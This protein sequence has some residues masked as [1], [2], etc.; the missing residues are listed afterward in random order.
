MCKVI[1]LNTTLCDMILTLE[2]MEIVKRYRELSKMSAGALMPK[3]YQ[4]KIVQLIGERPL[5]D[6]GLDNV[7]AKCLWDTGS[8]ISLMSQ[9]FKDEKF[10]DK[11]MHTVHEFLGNTLSV[12][13]ANNTKV[14]IE[15]VILLDISIGGSAPFEVPFLVT[16]EKLDNPI[17]GYNVIKHLV[18]NHQNA[19]PFIMNLIP[20]L[21]LVQAQVVVSAM[22]TAAEEPEFL[23]E[24][25]LSEP[26]VV[27]ARYLV[28]ARGKTRVAL[29]AEERDALFS[30]A[31]EFLGENDLV[32]YEAAETLKR[33]KSHFINV[34]IHNP[35]DA[36]IYLKKG[37]ILGFVSD[38]N[39]IIQFPMENK[40]NGEK[41]RVESVD[42][43]GEE[44]TPWMNIDDDLEL[45]DLTEEEFQEAKEMLLGE[46]EIFSKFKN[47]IGHVPEFKVPINLTD[48][49]PVSEPY[50]AIPRPLYDDVK[51]HI[52]NM[53]AHGWVRKS[54]SPYAS[55]M[56]CARKPD[57]SL[58]LCID[59]RRVNAKIIP[60]RQPIP[61]VQDILDGLQGQEWFSTIDMSQAYHQ[62]EI[63]E[64]SR[65]FTVFSTPWSLLEWIRIPYGLSNAPPCFQRFINETL[66]ELKDKIC[67]AYLDD[68][69]IYG[70]CFQEH[71]RN[72]KTVLSLLRKKGLK[73]NFKKCK[74]F[75][76]EVKYL[77]RLISKEGYRPDPENSKSLDACLV[78][79]TNIGKLRSLLGFL[80]YYRNFVM[81]FSRKMKPVYY[82]LKVEED[83]KTIKDK[84]SWSKRKITWLPEH[85][86]IIQDVVDYLKSPQVIAYPDFTRPFL[87]HCDA[88]N[89][90]LGGVLYQ[91]QDASG[92]S[93]TVGSGSTSKL[94]ND[95]KVIS[96]ASRTLSPA[97]KNYHLHSGKLEFLALKWCITEKF[98]H[99]LYGNGLKFTVFTDNNPLTYVLS[100]AKLNATGLRWVAQLSDYLFDIKYKPGK[101][102]IDADYLS[103][104][105]IDTFAE[106][107]NDEENEEIKSEDVGVIFN[108]ASRR[109]R[110]LA[111]AKFIN[112]SVW[113]LNVVSEVSERISREDIRSA[114]QQDATISPV[115]HAVESGGRLLEGTAETKVLWKQR[116]R[117]CMENGVLMRQTSTRK[118][119][120]LPKMYRDLHANMG[121]LG[122]EKVVDLARKRFYWTY[123]AKDIEH[124]IQKKCPCIKSKKPNVP[125]RAP[126][127]PV[128]S[129]HPFEMVSIDFLQLDRCKGGYKYALVICDHFTRFT[130]ILPTKSKSVNAAAEQIFNKFILYFG[131][132]L[133]IHSDQG[134]EFNN[135]L[136]KKLLQLSGIDKSRTTP[137]HPE[138]D[139]QPERF[140][141]TVLNML[142]CLTSD[143]KKDWSRHVAKLAFAYNSMVN[144]STGYS[145]FYL[146]FGRESRL[147]IDY[148][149]G[150]NLDDDGT[151][152]GKRRYD[153]FVEEWENSMKEAVDI[154]KRHVEAAHKCNEKS[155]NK[156]VRG[157]KV[158]VGDKV[159]LRNRSKLPKG[160]KGK[161]CSYWNDKNVP[162]LIVRDEA[163]KKAP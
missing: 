16:K 17:L 134:T 9:Q 65:K 61:R 92:V 24:V 27:P 18:L 137:Y 7:L 161:L 40:K 112:A 59:F 89:T 66:A 72:L 95:L 4:S 125:D 84:R 82:L 44:D 147:P 51:N 107:E 29:G 20:S 19:V 38:V 76:R 37:T 119:I 109:E 64:E 122:S 144:K 49:I 22:Q 132:P 123:M 25:K 6:V 118:Q 156:K 100:S 39:T 2:E 139:G 157:V 48:N 145:P 116:K 141:R 115:Y 43:E 127:K 8:Q 75:K 83:V 120:I 1:K 129:T 80:G 23:S 69:L 28:R 67:V 114:Q 86:Q 128:V 47:D 63:T 46:R 136:F 117:L 110:I 124:F 55:P 88:S 155:Y 138:G 101:L 42:V 11:E 70:R 3:K 26:L 91:R 149:F 159:L 94:R 5:V 57:G 56:V 52:N 50:R 68:I 111:D 87:I 151:S 146:L 143:Q 121:H 14:P 106:R 31:A 97:E 45:S 162:A 108:E 10:S 81:D 13:A 79:P 163:G 113:K 71:K 140:N 60:D 148:I 158:V 32:V 33:G 135:K 142:K 15:G 30:P 35:S 105:P 104:H 126:L 98:H 99:Y 96:F 53:L 21:S 62:G 93:E 58:R 130:Q 160:S 34:A 150:I 12:S 133:R 103:R 73:L 77:G 154:A 102:N 85:Q 131:F 41:A 90:G 74:F 153:N 152:C 78:A 36:E 54:T